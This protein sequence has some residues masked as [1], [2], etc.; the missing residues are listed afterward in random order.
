MEFNHWFYAMYLLKALVFTMQG[1]TPYVILVTFNSYYYQNYITK[2]GRLHFNFVVGKHYIP[3][4]SQKPWLLTLLSYALRFIIKKLSPSR[5]AEGVITI[6]EKGKGRDN[7]WGCLSQT[8][9]RRATISIL[10]LV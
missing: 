6:L 5:V 7:G 3:L 8:M 9:I 10:P 1:E 2:E 4:G